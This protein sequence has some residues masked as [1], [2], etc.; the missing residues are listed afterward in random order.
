[1][2]P[3]FSLI[4]SNM[5]SHKR[6]LDLYTFYSML[7]MFV[8]NP[9]VSFIG[10]KSNHRLILFLHYSSID[11]ASIFHSLVRT[12]SRMIYNRIEELKWKYW[13][14]LSNE[15]RNVLHVKNHSNLTIQLWLLRG[16][17]MFYSRL[18]LKY[19]VDSVFENGKEWHKNSIFRFTYCVLNRKL[20]QYTDDHS[21]SASYYLRSSSP[22]ANPTYFMPT[23]TTAVTYY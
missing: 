5:C 9:L 17:T 14:C 15:R 23:C 22:F 13:V 18:F 20:Y 7:T 19:A 12:I 16:H 4:I 11:L 8:P 10:Y 3:P 21:I 2:C 1:M 6:V